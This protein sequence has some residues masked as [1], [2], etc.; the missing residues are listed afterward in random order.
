MGKP[1]IECYE[2]FQKRFY[3]ITK[4]LGKKQYLVPYLMSS[5]PGST[6]QE[7]V[8]LSLFLRDNGMH[9]EQVQDFYPTPGTIST[10]MYYTELD[11]YTMEPVYVPKTPKEKAMQRALLQYYLPQNRQLVL[12]ALKQAGRQDLIGTKPNCLVAPEQRS[13]SQRSHADK[14]R[15][16]H[17]KGGV[18]PRKPKHSS[19]KSRQS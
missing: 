1:H 10:C 7:A 6:L 16:P 2:A 17:T 13:D 18:S 12:S 4:S 8:K 9:P 3:E 5:H 14:N 19:K 11:P 15:N